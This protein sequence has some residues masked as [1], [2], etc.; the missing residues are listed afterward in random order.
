MDVDERRRLIRAKLDDGR[1]VRELR[2]A[3]AA[4]S[5]RTGVLV[6]ISMGAGAP[7]AGC[8]A[9]IEPAEVRITHRAADGTALEFHEVCERLW[10]DERRR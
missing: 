2:S 9:P 4:G 1:L 6:T 5:R 7:C 8:D 3:P 10:N